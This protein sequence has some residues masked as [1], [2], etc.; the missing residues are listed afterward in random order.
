[1]F[2]SLRR[3]FRRA[4]RPCF[5]SPVTTLSYSGGCIE[6]SLTATIS[7]VFRPSLSLGSVLRLSVGDDL[8]ALGD[9]D[10]G[11]VGSPHVRSL[12]QFCGPQLSALS[13]GN[14]WNSIQPT[15]ILSFPTQFFPLSSPSET[16]RL[17]VIM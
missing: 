16:L 1:M 13:E 3:D 11:L 9:L 2:F 4:V 12:V 15:L 6:G 8:L 17:I 10:T 5:L 14:L 7:H